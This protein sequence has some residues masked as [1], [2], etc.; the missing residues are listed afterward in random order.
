M[1]ALIEYEN[2]VS[3]QL[4]KSL[5]HLEYSYQKIQNLN[6]SVEE[7]DE[8]T[9]EAWE[10]FAARFARTADIFF[11]K[12]MK[13]KVKIEDPGFNGT[14]RDYLNQAE[15]INLVNNTQS[16]MEI[17]ELRNI[18]AHEY[19]ENNLT[20]IFTKLKNYTPLLLDIRKLIA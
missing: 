14:F 1:K 15:K 10:A 17:R 5:T 13:L 3:T 12:Y 16:W 4:K 9:L 19:S 11:M 8:A 2:E 20:E 18:S 7:M 6:Q